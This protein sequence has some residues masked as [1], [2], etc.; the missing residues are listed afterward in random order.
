MFFSTKSNQTNP[1]HPN[2]SA[3][4]QAGHFRNNTLAAKLEEFQTGFPEEFGG[5]SE[6]FLHFVRLVV[7]EALAL[8]CS[9]PYPH[10]FLPALMEEKLRYARQWKSRQGR[11]SKGLDA[12]PIATRCGAD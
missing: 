10:L 6:A 1:A 3:V 11:V 4:T 7:N 2:R 9:T 12:D 5:E 8:A